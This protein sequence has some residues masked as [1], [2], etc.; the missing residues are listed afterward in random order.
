VPSIGLFFVVKSEVEIRQSNLW[1]LAIGHLEMFD[2]GR[3]MTC[4]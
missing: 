4:F 3:G 1:V 2:N